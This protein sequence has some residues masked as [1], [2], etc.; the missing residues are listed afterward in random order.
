MVFDAHIHQHYAYP[1]DPVKF[2]ANAK[3]G[4]V[5]GGN[6]F[7]EA[8]SPSI[9]SGEGDYRWK[10]RLDKVLEFTSQTPGFYPFLWIDPIAP[11]A[12]EQVQKSVEQGICGFK[13]ICEFHYPVDGMKTYEAIA[14]TG[15]P[16]MFHSGILGGSRDRISGKF[17]KPIEFEPLFAVKGLRFSLAHV[18][19]PWVDDYMGMIAKAAFT[20][21]P[22]FG[23]KMYI[24]LTPGTPGIYRQD[25]LRKIYLTA[26]AVKNKVLWGTDGITGEYNPVLPRYWQERDSKYMTE[27]AKDN[28]LPRQPG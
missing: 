11:D 9:G 6:I 25:A 24:D 8:P 23:N 18:G 15:K 7:S 10:A 4:G 17:N 14:E 20:Y 28:E 27:L 13:V 19:W 1:D 26:Y 2:L 21:D 3:A 16:L 22:D 5:D 12:I